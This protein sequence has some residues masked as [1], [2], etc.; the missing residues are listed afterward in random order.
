MLRFVNRSCNYKHTEKIYCDFYKFAGYCLQ[1]EHLKVCRK[2]FLLLCFISW[3]KAFHVLPKNFFKLA[4]IRYDFSCEKYFFVLQKSFTQKKSFLFKKRVLRFFLLFG[5]AVY[6]TGQL[7]GFFAEY[8][9]FWINC[10]F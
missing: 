2:I 7:F 6:R 1:K 10:T 4:C 9:R 8:G 5:G 3:K